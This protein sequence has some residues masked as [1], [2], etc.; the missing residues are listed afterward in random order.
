VLGLVAL[1]GLV[2]AACGVQESNT[3]PVEIFSEMHYSQAYRVQEP[4]RLDEPADSVAFG[5]TGNPEQVLNVPQRRTR[6][7]DPQVAGKL[8]TVNCSVCHGISGQGNGPASVHLTSNQSYWATSRGAP[9]AA[10]ADLVAIRND[11]T[12]DALFT[13]ISNGIIVMPSFGKLMA[14]EDIWDIVAYIKDEATG[15][16]SG[17]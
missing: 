17:R 5:N 3:Y 2:A 13:V 15:L 10:P 7:Y 16:G 9:Y 8:F 1:C 6:P 14:E 12:E 4:P 11:R